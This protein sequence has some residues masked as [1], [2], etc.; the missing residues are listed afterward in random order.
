M[1]SA[2]IALVGAIFLALTAL[3]A[4]AQATRTWVSGV[5]DDANPCDRTAP[6]KTFAGAI[7]KT[8]VS[9]I[10]NCLDPGGFGAVTITKS[11]TID[12]EDTVGGVL[13]A[14]TNGINVSGSGI[15]V[16]L[17][18]LDVEGSGSGL[19]G[20]NIIQSAAVYIRKS[21][22]YGFQAGNATGINFT[23][24]GTLVVDD[25]VVHSNA[26]GVVSGG[27]GGNVT[28]RDAIVHGN[29]SNGVSITAG[30]ATIENSTLA[31]NSGTGL[32]VNGSGVVALI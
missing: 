7:S 4:N 20:I 13:A 23:G 27:T 2:A 14:G 29:S 26:T 11:I 9:G 24:G 17:R 6:C 30:R 1:N 32:N 28:L 5:G 16:N 3:P 21:V 31:F 15:V 18:G 19:I 25:T 22:I 10:I 8:A 12:C